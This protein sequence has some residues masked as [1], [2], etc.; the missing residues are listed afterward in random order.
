MDRCIDE[1]LL[2][3][4][5][6][7]MKNKS[8]LIVLVAS[9]TLS[10]AGLVNAQSLDGLY[11]PSGQ[12]WTCSP[13]QIGMDG[14]A[15][16]VEGDVFNGVENRCQLTN[17][18]PSGAGTTYTA[19]CSA[20][21]EESREDLTLTP[22]ANGINLQRSGSTI[23]WERCGVLQDAPAAQAGSAP[24][25]NSDRWSYGNRAASIST[26]GGYFELSCDTF[27]A[28]STYPTARLV[29]PCPLCFPME[30]SNYTL[31]VDG[32]F[33]REYEFERVSNAEGSVSG[34]D[35]YPDWTE[36]LVSALMTG[37]TLDV[38]K[39]GNVIATFPLTG[40]SRAVGQLRQQ[41]N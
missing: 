29:A 33:S 18:R 4:G 40:S 7:F 41:C 38:L 22:T 8:P 23:Y 16:S 6:P 27:N 10:C 36:G 34:L 28:S 9:A 14:G 11:Q 3:T 31:R 15:L 39:Q 1:T 37:S 25:G 20:E 21:G 32:Q 30:T 13:E 17:P 2:N 19:V 12:S 24:Q 5:E 26:G 35:Y